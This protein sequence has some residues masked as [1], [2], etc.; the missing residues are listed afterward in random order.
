MV[1]YIVLHSV[2][3]MVISRWD[4]GEDLDQAIN[5]ISDTMDEVLQVGKHRFIVFNERTHVLTYKQEFE[6]VE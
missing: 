2:N 6:I 3:G 4:F 1:N 5:F